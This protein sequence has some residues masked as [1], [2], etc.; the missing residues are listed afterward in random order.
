MVGRL[1]LLASL[2][3]ASFAL[4]GCTSSTPD[5]DAAIHPATYLFVQ[6]ASSGTLQ[7][8]TDGRQA[9]VLLGVDEQTLWFTDRPNRDAGLMRT[10]AFASA[11]SKGADSFAEDPPNGALV[12]HGDTGESEVFVMELV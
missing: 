6:D 7:A 8:A 1:A 4:S 12:L 3:I 10:S 9:L 11:W 2:S 5:K